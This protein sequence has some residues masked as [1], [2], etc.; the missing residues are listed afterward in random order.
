MG[1]S[2]VFSAHDRG[3]VYPLLPPNCAGEQIKHTTSE[4]KASKGGHEHSKS[5]MRGVATRSW[6]VDEVSL[7]VVAGDRVIG[8]VQSRYLRSHSRCG[9]P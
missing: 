5:S 9:C 6:V 1:L 3:E 2:C 7:G 4:S 8:A